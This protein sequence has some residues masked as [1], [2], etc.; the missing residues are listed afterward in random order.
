[1]SEI[2]GTKHLVQL[3][4]IAGRQADEIQMNLEILNLL[5]YYSRWFFRV[6]LIAIFK[7]QK[8]M[9]SYDSLLCTALISSQKP[10][11]LK[12]LVAPFWQLLLTYFWVWVVFS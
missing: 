12:N 5:K 11:Q 9:K 3:G 7:V 4:L 2:S 8:S 10:C 6:K 1:M